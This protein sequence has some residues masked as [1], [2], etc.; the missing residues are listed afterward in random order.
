MQLEIGIK[1]YPHVAIHR[2][3]SRLREIV[4][5]QIDRKR[6]HFAELQI[7]GRI[8]RAGLAVY[9]SFLVKRQSGNV[10][11]R[12]ANLAKENFAILCR[13]PQCWIGGPHAWRNWQHSLEQ[14]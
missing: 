2:L 5:R 12:A 11:A 4:V 1:W 8:V 9:P 6:R 10:A 13:S 3:Q 7:A 14:S